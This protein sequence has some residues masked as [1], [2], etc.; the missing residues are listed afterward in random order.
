[1]SPTLTQLHYIIT[2]YRL[3]HFGRAAKVCSVTQPTLSMQIKKAEEELGFHIFD[4]SQNPL[5]PTPRGLEFIRQA[6]HV[7]SAHQELLQLKTLSSD[8]PTGELFVGIIPTLA[9]SIPP[10]F[11]S[12]FAEMYPGIT[13]RIVEK[14][15]DEI[16]DGLRSLK[17]D[18]GVLALPLM[19]KGIDEQKLFTEQFY[20]YAHPHEELLQY[21]EITVDILP[22]D[23]IWLLDKGHCL[24]EQSLQICDRRFEAGLLNNVRF[25]AG[26]LDT[27][28]QVIDHVGGYT[29]ITESYARLLTQNVRTAQVRPFVEPL[30]ARSVGG[31]FLTNTWKKNSIQHLFSCITTSL[32]RSLKNFNTAHHILPIRS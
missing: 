30:P 32:P 6:M 16:I 7:I 15:T 31:A 14:T 12:N 21:D 1:M 29:L 19:E 24:R 8:T 4:R 20:I 3:R 5:S 28:R 23:R 10:L 26:G 9:S 18:V 27:L 22:M 25:E 13:L 17:I 11:L 2:L